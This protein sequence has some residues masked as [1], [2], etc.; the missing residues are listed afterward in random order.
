MRVAP[1][2]RCWLGAGWSG[3]SGLDNNCMFCYILINM[4][5]SQASLPAKSKFKQKARVS[6]NASNPKSESI[7][8]KANP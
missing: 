8:R 6:K 3:R 2:L 5:T 4:T 1:V 7:P